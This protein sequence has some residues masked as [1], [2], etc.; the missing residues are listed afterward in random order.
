MNQPEVRVFGQLEM[1]SKATQTGDRKKKN[2]ENYFTKNDD[3]D[4]STPG[5]NNYKALILTAGYF[6]IQQLQNF[7]S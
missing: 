6:K 5:P 4:V 7:F 1:T 3:Q 2:K